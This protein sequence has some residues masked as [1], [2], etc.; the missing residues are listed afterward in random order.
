MLNQRIARA[1]LALLAIAGLSWPLLLS[2][3]APRP[4]S[5]PDEH[6]RV[7]TAVEQAWVAAGLPPLGDCFRGVRIEW[8]RSPE[9]FTARCSAAY[10]V[11]AER[12]AALGITVDRA[13]SCVAQR[14]ERRGIYLLSIP[15]ALLRP[16][17]PLIDASLGAAGH[18]LLHVAHACAIGGADPYD[19]QHAD[20]RIWRAAA[21]KGPAKALTVQARAAAMLVPP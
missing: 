21:P 20:P 13:A 1:A 3:C 5:R 17:Q 12:G 14:E 11:S 16:G 4:V 10:G 18:E 6:A 9:D 8:A 15:V 19:A 2:G 7:F